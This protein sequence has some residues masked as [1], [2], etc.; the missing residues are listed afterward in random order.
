MAIRL[1]DAIDS[2][3][4]GG[5]IDLLKDRYIPPK[6]FS[7][8][9]EEN[10]T[11]FTEED[12]NEFERN[13]MRYLK[14]PIVRVIAVWGLTAKKM[15]ISQEQLRLLG[16][17]KGEYWDILLPRQPGDNER[18]CY[19]YTEAEEASIKAIEEF[20]LSQEKYNEFMIK[21]DEILREIVVEWMRKHNISVTE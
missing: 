3:G 8:L 18:Y 21:K 14:P 19:R 1:I 5:Y 11:G 20:M 4:N 9:C 17:D 16:M 12:Y 2:M 7:E 13:P 6:W 10:Y 15:G